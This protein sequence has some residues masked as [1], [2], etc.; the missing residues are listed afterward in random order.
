MSVR[1]TSHAMAHKKVINH[2]RGGTFVCCAWDECDRDGYELYKVRQH[3][4]AAT[5]PCDSSV[6]SH[7][8]YV[9]CSERHRAY[10]LHS[11]GERAK[12][13]E[14]RYNGRI[15]GMLPPGMRNTIL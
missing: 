7:V 6:A 3:T 15:A 14:A 12:E 11:S 8:S 13:L 4:H 2:D 1:G 10:W 5:I 9:F